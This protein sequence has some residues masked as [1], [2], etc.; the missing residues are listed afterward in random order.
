MRNKYDGLRDPHL[1][2]FYTYG[3]KAHLE[4]NITKAFV[5]VL[6]SLEDNQ[7]RNV[8]K[9]LFEFDL[10]KGNYKC[11]Y[12]LQ[13]KPDKDLVDIFPNKVMFAFSPTG[14]K[15]GIDGL[16]TKNES[17]IKKELIKEAEKEHIPEDNRNDFVNNSLIEIMK[18]KE[19]Q[20]SIP[21]GW[22]FIYVDDKPTL[23]VAMENK[24]YDLDPYQLNNHI[25]K[26]LHIT[27]NKPE[28][29]YRKYTDIINAFNKYD[30]FI[31][32]QFNEYLI[33][34]NY[35]SI[36]D[37][38]SISKASED[39]RYKLGI[40]FGRDIL[41]IVTNGTIDQRDAQTIRARVNY[42]YLKEI[43]LKFVKEKIELWLS[44]G[45]RQNDAKEM[46]S[47][48]DSINIDDPN[49]TYYLTSFHLMYYRGRN[50]G[51]SYVTDWNIKEYIEY[52]KNNYELIRTMSPQEAVQLYEKLYSDKKINKD[53]L[54]CIYRRFAGKKNP[55]LVIPEIS[56][57]FSWSYEEATNLGINELGK[58]IKEK[59]DIALTE[60]K[61][62]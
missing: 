25:E 6:Q 33:I 62:K 4:N 53:K 17:E 20:S 45:S 19:N 15:W 24:L 27:I 43:N 48:I 18:I 23:V 14:N 57:L 42:P 32:S 29:I 46:Y 3:D 2:I 5:N 55:V 61:L 56:I 30:S 16:D 9:N 59:V 44:F 10:P 41:K 40:G 35:T 51:D 11:S 38:T 7:L 54:D 47:K 49:F 28:P 22:L 31:I 37:F 1:N 36:D 52:W 58:S 8:V 13:R 50:I 21:D 39:L 12:Y 26:S 60:M 34:L